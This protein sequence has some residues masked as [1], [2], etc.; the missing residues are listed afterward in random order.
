MQSTMNTV[1]RASAQHTRR[2]GHFFAV[3]NNEGRVSTYIANQ[4]AIDMGK[5]VAE[6]IRCARKFHHELHQAGYA[7]NLA[8][9]VAC[10]NPILLHKFCSTLLPGEYFNGARFVLPKTPLSLRSAD[11]NETVDEKM[12]EQ[13]KALTR[14]TGVQKATLADHVL[15]LNKN[16]YAT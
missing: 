5:N 16:G 7:F 1:H 9:R 14:R 11:D 6:D 10:V 2:R 8:R 12:E 15:S 3:L 13:E 4:D